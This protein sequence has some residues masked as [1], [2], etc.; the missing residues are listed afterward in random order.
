MSENTIYLGDGAYAEFT[1]YSIIVYTSNGLIKE[2]E[3]HLEA[4]E[5][6]A[7]FEFAAAKGLVNE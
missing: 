6:R 7:L 1:G 4:N 5:L 3:V 2:N